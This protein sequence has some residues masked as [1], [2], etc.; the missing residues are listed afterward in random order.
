MGTS[1]AHAVVSRWTFGKQLTVG[2]TPILFNAVST[3]SS[4]PLVLTDLTPQLTPKSLSVSSR[5]KSRINSGSCFMVC[6]AS[7]QERFLTETLSPPTIII[8]ALDF[9]KITKY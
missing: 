6:M 4:T 3:L 2:D 8:F 9:S 5:C 1:I 7:M